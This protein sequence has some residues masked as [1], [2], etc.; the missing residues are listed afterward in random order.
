L[1]PLY[2]GTNK[3]LGLYNAPFE[4]T[5]QT[6]SARAL[7]TLFKLGQETSTAKAVSTF[8]PKILSGLT[9]NVADFPFVI[10][11]SVVEDSS[12]DESLSTCSG[13]SQTFKSCVLEGTLGVPD[14]HAAAPPRLDLKR[15][16]GGFVPAFRDALL[17]REPKLLTIKDGTLS[18]SLIEGIE[19]RGMGDPCREAVVCPLRPTTGE[20]VIG[21]MVVGVNPRRQFDEDY[22]SFIQ[23]LDRQLATSLASVSLFETEVRR[24]LTAA[25]AAA[26]ERSRLS[27]ELSNQRN[28]LQRIAEVCS[29]LLELQSLCIRTGNSSLGMQKNA[30]FKN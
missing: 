19:W 16:R 18:E 7:Q 21:F 11:Y 25:E 30:C 22:Q 13:S 24:G 28:R 3:I 15:S 17:T 14:G 29:S 5:R 27:E 8:W 26:F 6:R 20:N 10:L 1:T 23:L 2:G 12:D 4:T 9:D